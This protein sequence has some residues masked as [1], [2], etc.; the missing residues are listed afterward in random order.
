MFPA[1]TLTAFVALAI[2]ASASPVKRDSLI[3]L[4]LAKTV[5]TTVPQHIPAADRARVKRLLGKSTS[6]G[7]GVGLN[8]AVTYTANVDVGSPP[9]TYNLIVDTGSANTWVGAD[10]SYTPTNTSKWTGNL[11]EV[12]YGS[13]SFIGNEYTDTVTLVEGLAIPNQM[14]GVAVD[15]TGFTAVDG[16]L[17]IGP[18]GLTNGTLLPNTTSLVPTV[19]NNLFTLGTIPGNIVSVSFVP[20]NENGTATGELTFGG[21]DSTKFTGDVVYTPVTTV[22]PANHY[23]GINQ[24]VSYGSQSLLLGSSG[25][26]DTGTTLTLIAS[27]AFAVYQNATGG[28][29]DIMTGLL[30]ITEDQLTNLQSLYFNIEN[31]MFEMTPNAQVWPRSLNTAIGG[32]ADSIYLVVGDLGQSSGQG[33]DFINGM[34]FLERFYSVYDSENTRVGFATTPFT[35]AT[36]N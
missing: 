32:S 34:T 17:G 23:W 15:S 12:I 28:I 33:L 16:V 29:L 18:V 9:T 30:T 14:I 21:T 10:K 8:Q 26:V 20:A 2:G 24:D 11:V 22:S 25:F 27:D 4:Q 19:T 36:T 3:T 13:G 1:A 35:N 6:V 31:T 5:N 7:V